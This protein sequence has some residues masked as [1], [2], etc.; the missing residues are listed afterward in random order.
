ME[1]GTRLPPQRGDCA[2]ALTSLGPMLL[3]GAEGSP[4]RGVDPKRGLVHATNPKLG[5]PPAGKSTPTGAQ[6]RGRN[7]RS[8]GSNERGLAKKNRERDSPPI[9]HWGCRPPAR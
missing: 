3:T 5:P 2:T 9:S 6:D 1:R 7:T 4:A 8:Q